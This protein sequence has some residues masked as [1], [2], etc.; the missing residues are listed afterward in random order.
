MILTACKE[1]PEEPQLFNVQP[2]RN[3]G[4]PA[5]GPNNIIL[6]NHTPEDS[7]SSGLWQINSD[8]TEKRFFLDPSFFQPDWSHD[9]RWLALSRDAQIYKMTIEKDSIVQLTG[10]SLHKFHPSWSPDSRWIAYSINDG[11]YA[12]WGIW[13]VSADGTKQQQLI[14]IAGVNPDWSP[15]GAKIC[16]LGWPGTTQTQK[17]LLMD[18]DGKN[19]R[20]VFDPV[21][22]GNDDSWSLN[23]TSFSPDGNQIVFQMNPTDDRNYTDVAA[24]GGNND[25]T[26]EH[27]IYSTVT[28]SDYGYFAGTSMAAPHVTGLAGLLL[29]ANSSLHNCDLEWIIKISADDKGPIGPDPSLAMAVSMPMK[30]CAT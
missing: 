21:K 22:Y 12:V 3:Y 2:R 18:A 6:F 1:A 24:P 4:E 10:D 8:G 7:G 19:L 14:R 17:L 11:D 5:W 30:R 23:H 27:D 26:E 15:D 20:T 28:N 13:A 29:A 16:F 9:G 25:G